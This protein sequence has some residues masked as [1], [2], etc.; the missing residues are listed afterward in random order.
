[1]SAVSA[2]RTPGFRP[3]AALLPAALASI[4]RAPSNASKSSS[5]A[6]SSPTR[7]H[8]ASVPAGVLMALDG[9]MESGN[10]GRQNAYQHAG[11]QPAPS[12]A[13]ASKRPVGGTKPIRGPR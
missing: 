7:L 10:A 13:K 1:V 4:L 11:A 6:G 9:L 8:G 3:L 12:L 2:W 5:D